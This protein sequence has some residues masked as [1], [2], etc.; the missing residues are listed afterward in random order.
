MVDFIR[1][2][3]DS[4]GKRL[5]TKQW[6]VDGTDVHQQKVQVGCANSADHGLYIDN[7]GAAYTRYAEGQPTFD[8]FSKL[9]LS[10]QYMVGYYE[11]SVEGYS[12]LFFTDL[13]NGGSA[14][15]TAGEACTVL[16]TPVTNN[17]KAEMTTHRY[18]YY[19]Q[20][21]SAFIILAAS[22]GDTGKANN[23]RRW[24]YYDNERGRY[25]ILDENGIGCGRRSSITGSPID[26]V[27]Y[28]QNWNTDKLD[29]TGLSGITLDPTK[30]YL[31]W[32]DWAFPAVGT[33]F[34]I[35]D[36][37]GNRVVCHQLETTGSNS[38]PYTLNANLPIR[39]SS[40]N[41]GVAGSTSEIRLIMAAVFSETREPNYTFWRYGGMGCSNR[42]VTTNTPITS[43]KAKTV[44]PDGN[45]NRI[46]TYPENL[47]VFCSGGEIK[48][49]VVAHNSTSYL[50]TG[51]TWSVDNGST[52]LCDNAS[53]AIDTTSSDYWVM[54]TYY[55]QEGVTH[56]DIKSMFELNDEGI[57]LNG[58]GSTQSIISFVAT[59]LNN[60]DTVTTSLDVSTRELW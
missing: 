32:M 37:S 15:F 25:F 23:V 11:F 13:Q 60:G 39:Y 20:G 17:A 55:C 51:D 59:K 5:Q 33:R 58:D 10:Q 16:S 40:I 22:C 34:G 35:F 54:K 21:S 28:Q 7:K 49:E 12:D 26:Y 18:H 30:M 50:L 6:T 57:S 27:V 45:I 29:G 56:I 9:K 19:S 52:L 8:G 4:T 46:N 31:Y 43:L 41:T 42:S 14:T 1:I 53:T 3:P 44:L 24:G 48:L 2:P 38:F 36:S 47:E